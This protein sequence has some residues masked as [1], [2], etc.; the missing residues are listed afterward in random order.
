[1]DVKDVGKWP[2]TFNARDRRKLLDRHKGCA[3]DDP[4][5]VLRRRRYK[6]R[7]SLPGPRKREFSLALRDED[8]RDCDEGRCGDDPKPTPLQI[9]HALYRGW[10]RLRGPIWA[11]GRTFALV[12]TPELDPSDSLQRRTDSIRSMERDVRW[13]FRKLDQA[14]RKQ[15]PKSTGLAPRWQHDPGKRKRRQASAARRSLRRGSQGR[16]MTTGPLK[17]ELLYFS[18]MRSPYVSI[19][20]PTDDGAGTLGAHDPRCVF[21]AIEHPV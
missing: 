17:N 10:R 12:P 6:R 7:H 1:M 9:L 21:A 19:T 8:H 13:A 16:T 15:S 5:G 11:I 2:W 4:L 14:L 18:P 3:N 20:R